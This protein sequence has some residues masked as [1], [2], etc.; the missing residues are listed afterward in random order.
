MVTKKERDK[1]HKQK[2]DVLTYYGNGYCKCVRCG[3]TD[4]RALC[5]DHIYGGGRQH[6]ASIQKMGSTF[7]HWLI[8]NNY[9]NGF[10]T[11]CVNCN[12]IK[13]IDECKERNSVPPIE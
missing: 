1:R 10:Q 9:P 13:R 3:F 8:Q 12:M 5:I 7:Y 4:I 11:L 2:V 6:I